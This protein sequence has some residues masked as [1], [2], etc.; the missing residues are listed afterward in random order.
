MSDIGEI[1]FKKAWKLFN[2]E[3]INNHAKKFNNHNFHKKFEEFTF[4]SLETFQ[5]KMK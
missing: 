5:K 4:E 1:S 3:D 2:S